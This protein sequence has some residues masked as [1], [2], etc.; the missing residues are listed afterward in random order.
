MLNSFCIVRISSGKDDIIIRMITILVSGNY[1]LSPYK[2]HNEYKYVLRNG[3]ASLLL[4]LF[5]DKFNNLGHSLF[6]ILLG[7]L[8]HD[9]FKLLDK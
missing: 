9:V 3:G 6:H 2:R 5:D 8:H 7:Y 1:A 4:Y